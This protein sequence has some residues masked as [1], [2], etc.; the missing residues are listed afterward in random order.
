MLHWSRPFG[1]AIF[2]LMGMLAFIDVL[3]ESFCGH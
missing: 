2:G 3:K 1:E